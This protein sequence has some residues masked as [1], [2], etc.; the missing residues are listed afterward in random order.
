MKIK[1]IIIILL[2]VILPI[3]IYM[4]NIDKKIYYLALGDSLAAG[5]N[6]Y[7]KLGYGYSDYVSDYLRERDLL[8]FYTNKY[9]VSGHRTTDLIRDIEDNREI[10]VNGK[11]LVLKNALTNADII[12]LSIGANDLFYKLSLHNIPVVLDDEERMKKYVDEVLIDIEK[13]I[14]LIK[15]YCKEDI[16]LIGYYNPLWHINLTF[17]EQAEPVLLYANDKMKLLSH[18]HN[19]YYVDIYSVFKQNKDFVPNPLDIHPSMD[20]YKIIGQRIINIIY[21]NIIN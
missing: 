9:A 5:Q 20:G 17:A 15:R 6:P 4:T 7:G 1:K 18:K 12:T 14:I 16:I 10:T 8:E 13:L 3:I 19:L 2:L 21:K 11:E